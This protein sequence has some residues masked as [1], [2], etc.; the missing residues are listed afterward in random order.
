MLIF[1]APGDKKTSPGARARSQAH[2]AQFMHINERASKC[3][4]AAQSEK[5]HTARDPL[6]SIYYTYYICG[7]WREKKQALCWRRPKHL[8]RRRRAR[9][10][11]LILVQSSNIIILVHERASGEQHNIANGVTPQQ[12][13]GTRK[14]VRKR[15][16]KSQIKVGVAA[17]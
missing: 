2:T 9:E 6:C 11:I 14:V 1:F 5:S 17:L 7:R 3:V 13:D 15:R 16:K 10:A 4:S 12:S 8:R